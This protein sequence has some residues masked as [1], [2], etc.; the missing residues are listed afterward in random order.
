MLIINAIFSYILSLICGYFIFTLI[1]LST[2]FMSIANYPPKDGDI[3]FQSSQS[4]Q[5]LAVEQSR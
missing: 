5:S 3:I 4:R 2:G 1:L